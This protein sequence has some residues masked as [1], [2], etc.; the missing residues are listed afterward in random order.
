MTRSRSGL[1]L[2]SAAERRGA[3]GGLAGDADMEAALRA[4]L[5]TDARGR[6]T[7]AS[8]LADSLRGQSRPLAAITLAAQVLSV[9]GAAACAVAFFGEG[10][11]R[12]QIMFATG[13]LVAM[14]AAGMI[15]AWFWMT[16][17][18]N[19]TLREVKRLEL[20]VARLA[21]G[22]TPRA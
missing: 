3:V 15:K 8:L 12:G 18:R 4:A 9:A 22:L 16:I 11:T 21:D 20:Q 2:E 13:F 19:R 14:N 1:A 5:A 17:H 7:V 10:T 6:D